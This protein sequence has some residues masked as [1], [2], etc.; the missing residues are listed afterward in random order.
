MLYYK[1]GSAMFLHMRRMYVRGPDDKARSL[2][3]TPLHSIFN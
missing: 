1:V 3:P 2:L